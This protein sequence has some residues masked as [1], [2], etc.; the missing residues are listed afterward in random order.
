MGGKG[1]AGP[2]PIISGTSSSSVTVGTGSKTFTTQSG[3]AWV[4]GERL[5]ATSADLTK[6]MVGVVSAYSG[7]SLT[8]TVDDTAGSGTA[9]SWTISV[10]GEKGL[11]GIQG[12]QGI[13]GNTGPAPTISG[14]SSTSVAAGIGSKSFVTQSGIAWSVGQRLRAVSADAAIT[15]IGTVTS[16]SGTSL[17]IN[18]DDAYGA[19][20]AA[21]WSISIAGE[22]GVQGPVGPVGATGSQGVQGVQGEQGIQGI[23]GVQ[24]VQGEQGVGI[25]PDATGTLDQRDA[26]DGQAQ[27]FKFLETDVSPFRLWIKASNT[28]ADWAGPSYIGGTAPVGDLGS[29]ADSILETFDYGVAA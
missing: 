8:L 27:G 23:Q 29:V 20:S 19:G 9:A 18:V 21:S 26:Y 28:T 13:Q 6:A 14:T 4:V 17:T 7:T 3:I 16:Y 22:K 10:A 1:D 11:Q 15:L 12:I 2:A 5:R 25:G 24:G